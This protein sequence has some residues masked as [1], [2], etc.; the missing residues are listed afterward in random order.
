MPDEC[1]DRYEGCER[2]I[3]SHVYPRLP[4]IP[5]VDNIFKISSPIHTIM[6]CFS[7]AT[8]T[9]C[10]KFIW[11]SN[12]FDFFIVNSVDIFTFFI[13]FATSLLIIINMMNTKFFVIL[14]LF[15]IWAL[16]IEPYSYPFSEFIIE[17]RT[18]GLKGNTPLPWRIIFSTKSICSILIVTIPTAIVSSFSYYSWFRDFKFFSTQ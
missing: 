5:I 17:F 7:M 3:F 14:W 1:S 10:H 18:I 13:L 16:I 11:V 12:H 8:F 2:V 9:Q 4:P 15:A 6:I